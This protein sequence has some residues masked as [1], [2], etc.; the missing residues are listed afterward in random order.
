MQERSLQLD[1][2]TMRRIGYLT[3]DMLVNR[4]SSHKDLNGGV[5]TSPQTLARL[6]EDPPE[7][8]QDF[9]AIISVLEE[10]VLPA[11]LPCDHPNFFAFIPGSSTLARRLGRSHC[12]RPQR[13]RNLVAGNARP[14][15][16]RACRA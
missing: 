11:F 16:D 4:M 8:G 5:D 10:D 7:Q 13:P 15:P 1:P 2:E 12:K 6:L 3:V 9:E 14:Q